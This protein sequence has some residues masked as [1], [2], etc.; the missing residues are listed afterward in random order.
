MTKGRLRQPL[1]DEILTRNPP[2]AELHSNPLFVNSLE[3]GVR[4][5]YAFGGNESR[6]RAAEIAR[7]AG[8][9]TSAAQRFIFSLQALGFLEKD[10][11]TKHYKLSARLLDFAY[12]YLRS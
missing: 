12:L 7:A 5:L 3:K 11:R 8:L 1:K 9:D 10:E 4:V 2:R 6:L